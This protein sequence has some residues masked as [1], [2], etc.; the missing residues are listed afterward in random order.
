MESTV[1]KGAIIR[2]PHF[3]AFSAGEEASMKSIEAV[4]ATADET[5]SDELVASDA[6]YFSRRAR[7]ELHAG[8]NGRSREARQVHLELAEAYEFRARLLT[9]L[10]RRRSA[11]E[12]CYAL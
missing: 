8:V 6:I 3:S 1:P 9:E 12:Q 5:E 11:A 7:E 10:L 4:L 2:S